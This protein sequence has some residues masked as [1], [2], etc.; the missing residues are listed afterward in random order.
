[1]ADFY[2]VFFLLVGILYMRGRQH[3]WNVRHNGLLALAQT[4]RVHLLWQSAGLTN[5][6]IS[7]QLR[8]R[9]LDQY[10]WV[11]SALRPLNWGSANNEKTS[12][13]QA[14]VILENWLPQEI[15]RHRDLAF[16]EHKKLLRLNRGVYFCYF[17]SGLLTLLL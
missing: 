8:L 14:R 7:S 11:R 15:T 1:M 16:V 4:L 6:V 12:N 3:R 9:H 13:L 2:A 10:E 17:L 5:E